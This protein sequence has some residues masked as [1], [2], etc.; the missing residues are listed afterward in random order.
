M[1]K[2]V[3][4]S[5]P[6]YK[7]GGQSTGGCRLSKSVVGES[8]SVDF[9]DIRFAKNVECIAVMATGF[10]GKGAIFENIF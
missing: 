6:H 1:L 8:G 9:P 3:P 7:E 10:N 5:N 4:E 2:K